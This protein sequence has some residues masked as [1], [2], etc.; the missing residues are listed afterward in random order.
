MGAIREVQGRGQ[1]ESWRSPLQPTLNYGGGVKM[2][3]TYEVMK[4][5]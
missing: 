2:E 4:S 5:I 3:E 1:K